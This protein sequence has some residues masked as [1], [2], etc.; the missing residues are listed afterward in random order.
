MYPKTTGTVDFKVDS[1][2][3]WIHPLIHAGPQGNSRDFRVISLLYS[4]TRFLDALEELDNLL[5][6][7][8]IADHFD[9]LGQSWGGMLTGQYATTWS[10]KGLRHLIILNAPASM[11]LYQ[12]GV[13]SLL[14]KFPPEFVATLRKHKQEGTTTSKEYQDS[15]MIFMK[16]LYSACTG[17]PGAVEAIYEKDLVALMCYFDGID[18]TLF[19]TDSQTLIDGLRS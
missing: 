9:L 16:K 15:M 13:N 2:R 4:M 8:G 18:F 19:L 10:P 1:K 3:A 11:E 7:L 6:K 14:D 17:L 12:K 5:A